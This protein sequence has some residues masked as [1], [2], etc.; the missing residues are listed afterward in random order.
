MEDIQNKSEIIA[1]SNE[2]I[3]KPKYTK[4]INPHNAFNNPTE[5]P[6]YNDDYGKIVPQISIEGCKIP[7]IPSKAE[8][9]KI[10]YFYNIAGGGIL[11]HLAI[12]VIIANILSL[13][14]LLILMELN[15]VRFSEI[16]SA[17]GTKILE[18]INSSSIMSGITLI[19]YLTANLTAFFIGCK[20]ADIEI[21]SLFKTQKLTGTLI[22]QYVLAG[23][24]IQRI[25]GLAVTVLEN[26]MTQIDLI[27]NSDVVKYSSPKAFIISAC[28]TCIIAPVTEEFLY[29]GFVMKTFSKVSQRFGIFISAFFF[30]I[31]HG[32]V[33]QFVLAFLVGIFMGYLNVKHNSLI[34]SICVHFAINIMSTASGFILNYAGN[35]SAVIIVFSILTF[36]IFFAGLIAFILFCRQNKLPKSSIHQ[37]FRSLNIF[38]TSPAAVIAAAVYIISLMITTF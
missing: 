29:R 30:G 36:I 3:Y 19:S 14:I 7:H 12:S 22:I 35:D 25:A 2:T 18:Y 20:F 31:M 32:N 24:F 8:K 13:I 33:A 26:I 1:E 21:K 17:E 4:T 16:Q 5:N 23:L 27:G 34:P 11:F 9:K 15:G 6:E 28:Y 37:Q 10:R 38:L